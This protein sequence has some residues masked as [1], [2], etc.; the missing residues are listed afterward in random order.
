MYT[1]APQ[2]YSAGTCGDGQDQDAEGEHVAGGAHVALIHKLLGDVAGRADDGARGHVRLGCFELAHTLGE[3][4][5]DE[6]PVPALCFVRPHLDEQ[7]QNYARTYTL[8]LFRTQ[9]TRSKHRQ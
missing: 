7:T 8:L 1:R 4:E 9:Q 6:L 2:G 3:S 5:V